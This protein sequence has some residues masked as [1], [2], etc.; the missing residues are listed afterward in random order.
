M[1][2]KKRWLLLY[3]TVTAV[4]TTASGSPFAT[5]IVESIGYPNT[6]TNVKRTDDPNAVLG[7][8]TTWF[9]DNFT[10]FPR[11]ETFAAS[12]A[13]P[14]FY[15]DLDGNP[16][17]AT[18]NPG[19]S[20]TVAFD[21]EVEDH[22]DNPYGIDFIVFG[23]AFFKG[24]GQVTA[25]TDMATY[26]IVGTSPLSAEAITVAVSPDGIHWHTYVDGPFADALFPTQAFEWDRAAGDWG[27]E[28][29]FTTPVD[30]QIEL[31]D[32]VGLSMADAIDLYDGSAGGTGFDLADSGFDSIRY[33]R[34]TGF[35]G[36][37]DA[38]ADVDPLQ[39]TTIPQPRSLVLGVFLGA[40]ACLICRSKRPGERLAGFAK[41]V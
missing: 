18:V 9:N 4:A 17:V 22:P 25:I 10:F 28:L 7:K 11:V 34:V 30:P 35:G 32:F 14:A 38:F 24:Y 39:L 36:E 15:S 20:I 5:T 23:N 1:E 40:G 37:V 13:A 6:P 31:E 27:K 2:I 12:V 16:V 3:G 26:P 29:S 33:V 21:H 8:P 41:S 19:Q